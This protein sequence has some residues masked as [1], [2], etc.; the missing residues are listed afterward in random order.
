MKEIAEK[1]PKF[2]E[3]FLDW[4]YLYD[5]KNP[6][7]HG[8]TFD[9]N[10]AFGYL[11]LEYFPQH[12][13]RIAHF[14]TGEFIIK[15]GGDFVYSKDKSVMTFKNPERVIAKAAGIREKQLKALE[16]K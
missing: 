14:T 16:G 4:M 12:G 6:V 13:I 1:Y 11:V 2:W 9:L 8:P 5:N 15:S 10:C 7:V 3:D